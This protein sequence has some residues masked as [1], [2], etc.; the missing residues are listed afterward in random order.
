MRSAALYCVDKQAHYD[1]DFAAGAFLLKSIT[2]H[3]CG[4]GANGD[5]YI[6]MYEQPIVT[7]SWVEQRCGCND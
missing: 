1:E 7:H 2:E 4:D 6:P 5:G 3:G